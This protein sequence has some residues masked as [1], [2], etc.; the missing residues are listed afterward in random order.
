MTPYSPVFKW[1]VVKLKVWD[2][3]LNDTLYFIHSKTDAEYEM[4]LVF[5]RKYAFISM[6]NIS[7]Y[8]D[9]AN[10]I[11]LIV[12]D[13]LKSKILTYLSSIYS[14][15]LFEEQNRLLLSNMEFDTSSLKLSNIKGVY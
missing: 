13:D 15:Y 8:D 14:D 1:T 3:S 9:R 11:D 5:C 2:S 4:G 12:H 7:I 10:V 6:Y